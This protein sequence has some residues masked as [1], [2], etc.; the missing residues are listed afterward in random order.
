VSL[1]VVEAT[2]RPSSTGRLPDEAL[3]DDFDEPLPGFPKEELCKVCGRCRVS[4]PD[5]VPEC[6]VYRAVRR[7]SCGDRLASA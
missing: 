5:Y 4:G 6:A 1:R 3:P 2:G 7:F